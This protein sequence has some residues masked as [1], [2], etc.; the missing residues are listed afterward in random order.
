MRPAAT[1]SV[2]WLE[3]LKSGKAYLASSDYENPFILDLPCEYEGAPSLHLWK[4]FGHVAGDS[5]VV[6]RRTQPIFK[7]PF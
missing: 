2:S 6:L 3:A 5:R 7:Y 4:A 1:C